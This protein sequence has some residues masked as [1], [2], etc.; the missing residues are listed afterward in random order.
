MGGG[1]GG[2]FGWGGRGWGTFGEPVGD[3]KRQPFRGSGGDEAPPQSQTP[4]K[5][6]N[7]NALAE[8]DCCEIH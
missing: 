6:V 8:M 5:M 7:Q 2:E 1:S 4:N 3:A